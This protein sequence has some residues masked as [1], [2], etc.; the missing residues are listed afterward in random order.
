[1]ISLNDIL[2]G[3]GFSSAFGDATAA[4]ILAGKKATTSNG[5][6]TGTMANQNG[7]DKAALDVLG[8]ALQMIKLKVPA[9]YFDG[10][11]W[12]YMQDPNFIAANILSGLNI[13]GLA[14]SLVQGRRSASGSG[15][16]PFTVTGLAFTPTIIHVYINS[17][18]GTTNKLFG[19]MNAGS[20][21]YF[22]S[23]AVTCSSSL[24]NWTVAQTNPVNVITNGFNVYLGASG[25]SVSW[26]AVE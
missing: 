18:S 5:L 13:F 9:G 14:G 10:S 22:R 3:H 2:K 15:T 16:M 25:S 17:E 23:Y 7:A 19:T 21:P 11:T 20:S 26:M 8:N 1:M 4:Q 12:I 24:T 6:I